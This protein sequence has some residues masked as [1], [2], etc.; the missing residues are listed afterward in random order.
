LKGPV[1]LAAAVSKDAPENK[2]T[3]L[4]MVGDS[5]FASN[6]YYSQAGNGNLFTNTVNWL[7]RDENFISIKPKSAEDRRIEMTEAQG[8]MVS[9]VMV[10]LLPVGILITGVSVW[11]KRRK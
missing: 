1:T 11:M 9:Y 8:R 7:A 3:R 6:V 10:L 5:D 4:V 2:K